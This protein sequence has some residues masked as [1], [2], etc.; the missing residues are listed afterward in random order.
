M[1]NV[2]ISL[3][4]IKHFVMYTYIWVEVGKIEWGKRISKKILQTFNKTGVLQC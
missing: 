1:M 3:N 2:L 4:V